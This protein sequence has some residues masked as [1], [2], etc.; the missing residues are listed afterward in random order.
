MV[1]PL[2]EYRHCTALEPYATRCKHSDL[3]VVGKLSFYV[4]IAF[5]RCARVGHYLVLLHFHFD[6]YFQRRSD[7]VSRTQ[8]CAYGR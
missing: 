5:G 2:H 8:W 7:D 3:H 6:G 4:L 1:A